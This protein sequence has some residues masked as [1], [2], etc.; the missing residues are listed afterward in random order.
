MIHPCRLLGI[1][2]AVWLAFPP[3]ARAQWQQVGRL[4]DGAIAGFAAKENILFAATSEGGVF[5]TTNNGESWISLKQGL[6]AEVNCR[7]LAVCGTSLLVG[8][9]EH[10][11][12]LSANNGGWW[13][14]SNAGLPDGAA[15]RCFEARGPALF[16]GTSAGVFMSSDT[17][18]SWA[19][20]NS[21]L[22]EGTG[23]HCLAS[24]GEEM[25]AATDDGAV[26]VTADGGARWA[27]AAKGLPKGVHIY[28]LTACQGN[29]LAGT[30]MN[31]ILIA[32]KGGKGWKAV[33]GLPAGEVLC[34]AASGSTLFVGTGGGFDLLFAKGSLISIPHGAGVLTS[35]NAGAK[36]EKLNKGLRP[37]PDIPVLKGRIGFWIM[38][39]A[40]FGPC[41]FA[42]TEKGE[43]W[44]MPLPESG[45][46]KA[47]ASASSPGRPG[48]R[49]LP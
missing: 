16:A 44:R 10:G 12:F 13:T 4:E 30:E 27:S 2:L 22:P 17:G 21:G 41:L 46:G 47:P 29:L 39:M 14:A 1:G 24:N 6:P 32:P 26:Y 7:C 15:I 3:V 43:I 11:V 45:V 42:G 48:E 8:T 37:A 40:V 36:W 31:R 19:A 23:V 49:I 33:K 38:G 28:C 34:F 20:V 18:A 9:R 25:L 5:L 35:T